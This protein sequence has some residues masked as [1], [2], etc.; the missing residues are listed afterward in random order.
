MKNI[1]LIAVYLFISSECFCQIGMWTWMKGDSTVNSG[2][3]W[4]TKGIANA[5]NKPPG[6]YEAIEFKDSIG[7]FW[8]FGGLGMGYL[9]FSALWKY[10]PSINQWTWIN[11]SNATVQPG[12][13]GVQGI[14]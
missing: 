2:A 13:Y 12:S 8:L 1:L 4:G 9:E 14:P 6:L 3:I 5:S 10:N 7:N 11:G